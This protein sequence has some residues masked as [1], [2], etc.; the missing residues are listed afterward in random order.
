[1]LTDFRYALRMLRRN[2]GFAATA[3]LTL[4]LGTG[5]STA[6]F[7]VVYAVL[8]KPLPV[9]DAERVVGVFRTMP[10]LGRARDA[11]SGVRFEEWRARADVFAVLAASSR[12]PFDLMLDHGAERVEGEIVSGN[13]F[14]LLGVPAALGRVLGAQ[15][16]RPGDTVPCVISEALWRHHLGTDPDVLGRNIMSS[17]VSMTIVGVVSDDF[18]RW[19]H[20]ARIWAPYRLTPALLP[21][22][23]L[24][25]DGYSVFQVFARL[26]PGVTIA[27]AQASLS[28][29]DARLDEAFGGADPDRDVDIAAIRTVAVDARLRRSLWMLGVTAGLVLALACA[30]VG[31]Q[32]VARSVQRR[33]EMATRAALGGSVRRLAMQLVVEIAVLAAAGGA[34]GLLLAVWMVPALMAA[35]PPDISRVSLTAL[36]RP[37]W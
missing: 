23:V 30:N 14:E 8:L 10:S 15:D 29:L 7:S 32:L 4:A 16:E 28:G 27:Q 1:M 3:V 25:R 26:T 19:R 17:G 12:K 37:A 2:P 31:G 11:V 24:A 22:A 33:R 18:A 36:D 13:F 20:P 34:A 6:I 9:A 5:V 21:P 35:A